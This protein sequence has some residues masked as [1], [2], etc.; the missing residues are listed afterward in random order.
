MGRKRKPGPRDK[1]DRLMRA[2]DYGNDRVQSRALMFRHFRGD[3][4]IGHEMSCAGRLMLVGAFD[5]MSEPP[6]TLLSA[7]LEY[8]NGY[9]GNYG[10][11]AKIGA[12]ERQDRAHDSVWEDARGRWFDAMDERLRSAGHQA[13]KA[14]H[15]VSVD[16]HWFPDEDVSWAARIINSRF[17]DKKLPVAGEV[18]CDSDWAM[19]D[20]L[21]AGALA[22]VGRQMRRAA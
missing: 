9:W 18:A 7:I 8:A 11:G 1:A 4:S 22:L 14:V 17:L 13:R 21:R 2:K 15:E 12:Y 10:G 19:L 3:S 5:G 6:E 20:L 16:R